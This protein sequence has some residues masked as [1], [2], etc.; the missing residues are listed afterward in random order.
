M[1]R[2]VLAVAFQ[3]MILALSP[4]RYRRI[5]R[6]FSPGPGRTLSSAPGRKGRRWKKGEIDRGEG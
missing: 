3:S 2:S 5:E 6:R 1:S 4:S